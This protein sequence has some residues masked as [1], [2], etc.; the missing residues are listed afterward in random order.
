MNCWYFEEMSNIS[1]KSLL[2]SPR[3]SKAQG[4]NKYLL[5]HYLVE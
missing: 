1:Q 5:N 2:K 3:V 4:E